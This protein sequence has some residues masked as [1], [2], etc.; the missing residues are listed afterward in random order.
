MRKAGKMKE[1]YL[2]NSRTGKPFFLKNNLLKMIQKLIVI[3]DIYYCYYKTHYH[4]LHVH[5]Y[6]HIYIVKI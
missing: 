4:F 3:S 5:I 2:L 1:G 6:V